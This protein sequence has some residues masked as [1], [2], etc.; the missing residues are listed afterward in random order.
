MSGARASRRRTRRCARSRPGAGGSRPGSIGPGR[1]PGGEAHGGGGTSGGP[2]S[3]VEN[4]CVMARLVR[5][6]H[7]RRARRPGRGGRIAERPCPWVARTSRAMT[8]E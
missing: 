5:A 6:T 7:E 4:P 2:G 1:R 8:R 3:G